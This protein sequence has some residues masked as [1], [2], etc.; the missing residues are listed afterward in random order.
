MIEAVTPAATPANVYEVKPA[1]Q[2]PSRASGST[3]RQ[4]AMH[5][6]RRDDSPPLGL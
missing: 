4:S 2:A 5:M 1:E 6:G 3:A